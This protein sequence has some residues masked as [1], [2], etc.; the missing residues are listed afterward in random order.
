MKKI[1]CLYVGHTNIIP[2]LHN[3]NW[4]KSDNKDT[5]LCAY[6]RDC[7][8]RDTRVGRK[9]ACIYNVIHPEVSF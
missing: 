3:E 2:E 7:E 9:G 4:S 1:I 6:W 8:N 5:S